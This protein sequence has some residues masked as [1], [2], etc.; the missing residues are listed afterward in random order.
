MP[1]TQRS[2]TAF[3]LGVHLSYPICLSLFYPFLSPEFTEIAII[4]LQQF[5]I[6][7][8][9]RAQFW[10][11]PTRKKGL[12]QRQDGAPNIETKRRVVTAVAFGSV[13]TWQKLQE[14]MGFSVNK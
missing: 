9:F 12:C 8:P 7:P 6:N 1:W 11:N 10:G 3:V 5:W 4:F 13:A 14:T 2:K